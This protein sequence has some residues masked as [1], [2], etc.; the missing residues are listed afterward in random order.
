[1]RRSRPAR[2]LGGAA[3]GGP[4][5][6]ELQELL[7]ESIDAHGATAILVTHEPEDAARLADRVIRLAGRPARIREDRRLPVPRA[8]R[9]RAEVRALTDGLALEEA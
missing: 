7:A 8:A 3:R 9:G 2:G 1:M 4:L 5:A 6:R